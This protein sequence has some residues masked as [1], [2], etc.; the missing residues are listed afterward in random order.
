MG[1]RRGRGGAKL[2]DALVRNVGLPAYPHRFSHRDLELHF[3][4]RGRRGISR[5]WAAGATSDEEGVLA[6]VQISG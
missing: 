1:G 3:Q 2:R 4:L 5:V 6:R